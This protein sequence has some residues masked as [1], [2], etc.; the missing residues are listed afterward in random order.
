MPPKPDA[1]TL[2]GIRA[3]LPTILILASGLAAVV[4][5]R[6]QIASLEA[7]MTVVEPRL[8]TLEIAELHRKDR[9]IATDEMLARMKNVERLLATLVC[10][11]EGVGSAPCDKAMAAIGP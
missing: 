4:T 6:V 8:A 3:W 1:L 7:R 10:K 5:A 2:G 11:Q 9:D